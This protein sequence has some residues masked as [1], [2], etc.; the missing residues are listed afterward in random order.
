MTEPRPDSTRLIYSVRLLYVSALLFAIA[1]V[2]W[3]VSGNGTGIGLAFLGVA[4]AM[5]AAARA[6]SSRT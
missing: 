4:L 1:G 2:I 3:L 6:V 5:M